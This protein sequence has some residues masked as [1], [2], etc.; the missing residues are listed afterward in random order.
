[1]SR[2]AAGLHCSSANRTS[3]TTRLQDATDCIRLRPEWSKAHFRRGDVYRHL[4]YWQQAEGN[5]R[6]APP[7]RKSLVLRDRPGDCP[8][9][10]FLSPVPAVTACFPPRRAL[11]VSLPL[12][13]LNLPPES[14]SSSTSFRSSSAP[15][16]FCTITAIPHTLDLLSLLSLSLSLSLSR[17]RALSLTHAHTRA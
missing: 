8:H 17:A 2:H 7:Q 3:L 1:M 9:A 6:F 4:G 14:C 10:F 13:P 11:S 16:A 5:F 15:S 12:L